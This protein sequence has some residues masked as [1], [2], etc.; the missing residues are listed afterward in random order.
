M[1]RLGIL[2]G[3]FDPVHFGH[4]RSAV[5][6]RAA[7]ALD[8]L[9]L[10]PARVSP[11][12]DVPHADAQHR[13]AMLEAAVGNAADLLVDGRELVRPPPS[14]TV[15]TLTDIADDHP[16]ARLHLVIGGDTCTTFD[17]WHRW[18]EILDLAHLVVM[19]RPGWPAVLPEA[20][21]PRRVDSVAA[22]ETRH[23]GAVLVQSV[24]QIDISATWIRAL[25]AEGGDLRYLVPEAVRA[26]IER[27]AL[28]QTT[29]ETPYG[30]RS[31]G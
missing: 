31:T 26:Y 19:E 15:D 1:R 25:A 29:D 6:I 13:R 2:G 3:T 12:R 16:G 14:Y 7:L 9:L 17:R 22:L 4:L 21:A 24:T 11:H 20:L 5:E 28:Y 10:I 8:A 30:D 23:A 27:E 18:R